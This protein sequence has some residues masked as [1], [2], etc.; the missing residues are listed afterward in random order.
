MLRE[1]V[2]YRLNV[3]HI[4]L[5]PLRQRKDDIPALAASF[6]RSINKKNECSVTDIHPEVL[7]QF[8]DY[9]W[10]GNVRELR[11]VLERAIIVAREGVLMPSHLAPAFRLPQQRTS[12][13]ATNP[14][15]AAAPPAPAPGSR[16]ADSITVEAGQ[17]LEEV[18]KQYIRLTLKHSRTHREAAGILGIS[19]RTLH[20]RLSELKAADANSEA[21]AMSAS[22]N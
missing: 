12:V 8:M 15:P 4:E 19:L 11:N 20:K 14:A 6:I 13:P 10:P 18:E 17:S 5:P 16:A 7:W 1:D 22:D 9:S 2:Y 3:F 21:K